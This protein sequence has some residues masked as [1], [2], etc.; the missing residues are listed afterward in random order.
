MPMQP[1]LWSVNGLATELEIDRRTVARR[2]RDVPPAGKRGGHPVWRMADALPALTRGDRPKADDAPPP[3]PGFA[4]LAG[5]PPHD[6]MAGMLL[7]LLVYRLPPAVASVTVA[8]GAPCRV[9]FA[10]AEVFKAVGAQL[11]G[12]VA[13]AVRLPPWSTEDDPTVIAPDLFMEVNWPALA[14]MAGEPLD[15]EAWAAW[16]AERFAAPGEGGD[17]T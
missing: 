16:M 11:V 7:M 2:L 8:A 4:W 3:P 6:A 5:L 9:A 1:G 13:R 10:A 17:A 14:E 15:P 12:E